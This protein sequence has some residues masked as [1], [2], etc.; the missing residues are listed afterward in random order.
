MDDARAVYVN[1]DREITPIPDR[2]FRGVQQPPPTP[3]N[4]G[5]KITILRN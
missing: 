1:V 3:N 2:G 4:K 5:K